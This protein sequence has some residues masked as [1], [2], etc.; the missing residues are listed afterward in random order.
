MG[1]GAD[2]ASKYAVSG[3]DK[4]AAGGDAK[5]RGEQDEDGAMGT[6]EHV[7]EKCGS[8]HDGEPRHGKKLLVCGACGK[9]WHNSCL[10]PALA[11]D[12]VPL[13]TWYCS[14]CRRIYSPDYSTFEEEDDIGD[15]HG[16]VPIVEPPSLGVSSTNSVTL[17]ATSRAFL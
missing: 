6:E 9:G 11:P 15:A 8:S 17:H 16:G 2:V 1:K 7:C 5:E 10:K 13:G 3:A 4:F 14:G 12:D